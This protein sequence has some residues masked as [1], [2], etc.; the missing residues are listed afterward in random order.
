[1][2]EYERIKRSCLK[3]GELWEDPEFPATQASV[4]YHQTPPF[5]FQW[6][7]PKELCNR[8]I[9]VSDAPAQFD[10]IPGKMGDKW[11]VSCL[12]VLHLSKGLFYRVVPADQDFGNN[13]EP[14]GSPSAEY[15]GVFRFRLW[16]CGAWVEVL[17]DDRLPAVHG[18][19]AF[20]Q[21]RHSDQFWPALLEKAYAKSMY[22]Q[23]EGASVLLTRERSARYA[24]FCSG[25]CGRLPG[26]CTQGA[27]MHRRADLTAID[28]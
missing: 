10:V 26:G 24:R 19:L 11:L 3:R 13:G 15:A 1:M 21:S 14:P 2:S 17:V 23:K 7:R 16:W 4:F 27:A 6:K 25:R 28:R 12:G 5:Q 18:R 9:F 8:P 20:V 22:A